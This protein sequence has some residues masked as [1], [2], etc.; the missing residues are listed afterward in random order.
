VLRIRL[1]PPETDTFFWESLEDAARTLR[2][3]S[4]PEERSGGRFVGPTSAPNARGLA[5]ER[6]VVFSADGNTFQGAPCGINEDTEIFYGNLFDFACDQD[7]DGVANARC[8]GDD[9]DDRDPAVQTVIE[10]D[11][12]DV[13][14][15]TAG[16]ECGCGG[17]SAAILFA[18]LAFLRRRRTP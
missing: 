5:V 14:P 6:G 16:G 7:D 10:R 17:G 12:V 11:G 4:T 9:A 3:E 18:P 15:A 8:D 1:A 13:Q 2:P